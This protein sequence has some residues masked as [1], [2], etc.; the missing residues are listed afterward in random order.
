MSKVSP[1]L[2]DY[3]VGDSPHHGWIPGDPLI[4]I[5][6][7]FPK[8]N[9]FR[10][11][12]KVSILRQDKLKPR[13][14]EQTGKTKESARKRSGGKRTH[15]LLCVNYVLWPCHQSFTDFIWFNVRGPRDHLIFTFQVNW[16]SGRIKPCPRF[17]HN[18]RQSLNLFRKRILIQSPKLSY[19]DVFQSPFINYSH[20]F[21]HIHIKCLL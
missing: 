9:I 6:T 3:S 10:F 12:C 20:N 15:D 11:F 13:E 21:Y 14:A 18:K 1:V 16:G 17:T 7:K 5:M 8:W 4:Q 19:T 2:E